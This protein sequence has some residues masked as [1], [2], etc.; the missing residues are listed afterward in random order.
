MIPLISLKLD[1]LGKADTLG[2]RP[3][4]WNP[5]LQSLPS[6]CRVLLVQI[7]HVIHTKF[8]EL[9]TTLIS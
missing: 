9:A 2:L 6:E 7:E 4:A 5:S 8:L 1:L 3:T